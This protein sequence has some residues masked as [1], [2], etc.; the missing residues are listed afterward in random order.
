MTPLLTVATVIST[1][2]FQRLKQLEIYRR[3]TLSG[4]GFL[5][6]YLLRQGILKMLKGSAPSKASTVAVRE[7]NNGGVKSRDVYLSEISADAWSGLRG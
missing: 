1:D 4:R 7:S 3:M 6:G 2:F 5:F